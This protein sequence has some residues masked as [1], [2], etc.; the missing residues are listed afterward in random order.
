M[1]LS[2]TW[3]LSSGP[4]IPPLHEVIE[5]FVTFCKTMGLWPGRLHPSWVEPKEK[6][7]VFCVAAVGVVQ[8]LEP[9]KQRIFVGHSRRNLGQK[10][11]VWMNCPR[12]SIL[13]HRPY[14]TISCGQEYAVFSCVS[15]HAITYW[16]VESHVV[17]FNAKDFEIPWMYNWIL[18]LSQICD[19]QISILT[20]RF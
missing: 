14:T 8:C 2:E 17:H 13:N 16:Y 19:P 4:Q 5:M 15:M 7:F 3:S 20:S 18:P 10:D 9:A 11:T 12:F 1:L 6:E